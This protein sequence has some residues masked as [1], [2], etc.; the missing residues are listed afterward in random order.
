MAEENKTPDTIDSL[1]ELQ[2]PRLLGGC[3]YVG[4]HE[5]ELCTA[6]INDFREWWFEVK[7]KEHQATNAHR[8]TSGID[9]VY[10]GGEPPFAVNDEFARTGDPADY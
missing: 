4:V 3:E 8:D 2:H 6:N 9:R 5:L 7:F 1:S 10:A